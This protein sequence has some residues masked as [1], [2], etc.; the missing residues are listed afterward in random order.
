MEGASGVAFMGGNRLGTPALENRLGPP[1]QG[2]RAMAD[3]GGL[4]QP[5]SH[6]SIPTKSMY[7]PEMNEGSRVGTPAIFTRSPQA[8]LSHSHSFNTSPFPQSGERATTPF[9]SSSSFRRTVSTGSSSTRSSLPLDALA[10]STFSSWSVNSS[11]E[12]LTIDEDDQLKAEQFRKL[13]VSMQTPRR[14]LHRSLASVAESETGGSGSRDISRPTLLPL[15]R[16]AAPVLDST[17]HRIGTPIVST[18]AGAGRASGVETLPHF[19]ASRPHISSHGR[20]RLEPRESPIKSPS[21]L[22]SSPFGKEEAGEV[23]KKIALPSWLQEDRRLQGKQESE[24]EQGKH[25]PVWLKKEQ[26]MSST[27]H[28][29]ENGY[30]LDPYRG[31]RPGGGVGG[32]GGGGGDSLR[33]QNS[34]TMIQG[35][36]LEED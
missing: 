35:A 27:A 30:S 10:S 22:T 9:S 34:R 33:L 24:E 16:H 15:P 13:D 21:V 8:V 26:Q 32:A 36:L 7:S 11:V 29:E 17:P 6:R 2:Y 5:L 28:K 19:G 14:Q 23:K 18:R 3:S 4:K 1:S 25:V 31:R 12:M 20:P